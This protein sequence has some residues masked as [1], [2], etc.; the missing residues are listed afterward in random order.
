MTKDREKTK[1]EL[2][3]EL[4]S[5]Q[6]LLDDDDIPMLSE[7]I[8]KL[9]PASSDIH[10]SMND[11]PLSVDEYQSLRSA[12]DDLKQEFAQR[13][14]TLADL[15]SNSDNSTTQPEGTANFL[16][17]S[18]DRPSEE[19]N[20]ELDLGGPTTPNEQSESFTVQVSELANEQTAASSTL[21]LPGQQALFNPLS[22]AS[23]SEAS[24]QAP[25][26]SDTDLNNGRNTAPT[27]DS[28]PAI[29]ENEIKTA[30]PAV[31]PSTDDTDSASDADNISETSKHNEEAAEAVKSSAKATGENPFLPQHIRAR[32]RGN[33]AGDF[34]LQDT[35]QPREYTRGQLV[36]ELIDSVMP[37]IEDTLRLKLA[38]MS[39]EQIKKLLDT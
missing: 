6:G 36:N 28:P 37:D 27:D 31:A 21:P 20:L 16:Q 19:E 22:D 4:E 8:E 32:L 5:I 13:E 7:V 11:R 2:L 10:N 34:A 18:F 14:N 25:E 30:T 23:T 15:Q 1:T 38:A 3:Q 39:D 9:E 29:D 12:Y 26:N 17:T 24:Q 35:I 33:R